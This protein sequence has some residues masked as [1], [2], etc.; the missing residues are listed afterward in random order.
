MQHTGSLVLILHGLHGVVSVRYRSMDIIG[1]VKGI[2]MLWR[3]LSK[4][5]SS[6]PLLSL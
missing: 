5:V 3:S 6:P 4:S 1:L 2:D